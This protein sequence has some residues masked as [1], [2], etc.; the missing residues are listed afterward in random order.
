M[1]KQ[2]DQ[3]T[4][5]QGSLDPYEVAGFLFN[6]GNRLQNIA[7]KSMD[8]SHKGTS[9]YTIFNPRY[10]A[11][12]FSEAL[13][14]IAE[15]PTSFLNAGEKFFRD[16]QRLMMETYKATVSQQPLA[17]V[18]VPEKTDKRFSNDTWEKSL[19]Y[20]YLKQ[21]YLLW[22]RWVSEI[23]NDL[24]GIDPKAAHK[25]QFYTR[26]IVDALSPSN[27][28]LSNPEAARRAVE[29]NGK[30]VFQGI[31]NF[32]R[33]L[34]E[35][36]GTLSIKMVD[37]AAFELGK[38]IATTSG[39]VVYQNDIIQLIQYSPSTEQVF[40]YPIVLIPP[41][42]NR[43]Y[44]F[45]LRSNNSFVK[46][47]VDQGFTVFMVSWVNPDEDLAHKRYEDYVFE[48]VK[49][50]VDVMKEITGTDKV[51][52][53][54]YCIGGNFL[55][56]Y[57]GYAGGDGDQSLNTTSYMAT[58]FDF[59]NSGDLQVFIDEKQLNDIESRTQNKGFLDG[60]TLARTF[61]ILRANDLIWS[62]VINNYLLGEEP[63]AF[64][65]LYWNSHSTNL[66][67]TMYNYYLRNMFHKNLLIKPG[68]LTIGGRPLNLADS[69]TPSF[70]LNTK[71]DHIAPWWCGYAGTKVFSG[72]KKF[73]LGGSGHVAGIFNHPSSGKYGYWTNDDVSKSFNEWFDE[74]TMTPGSW[75]GEWV[76]WLKDYNKKM[77]KARVPGSKM[78]P[79]IEDA[80]GSFVKA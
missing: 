47:L 60:E 6:F 19:Q 80:P 41:C 18:I 7:Q 3:E 1:E 15:N 43:F 56:T 45:D 67:A 25:V 78:H 50:S 38:N 74:A 30:S 79:P 4:K 68:G 29:T 53:L 8:K 55:A 72:P 24:E 52:A 49:A 61:N 46:W 5:Q 54:G 65:L 31:S 63:M 44:I 20:S 58:L 39:K 70:I 11:E 36:S 51:N 33:D 27:Y 75:W 48:G 76:L 17:N 28:I 32:L 69:T 14:K 10:M 21:S 13:V 23:T 2:L 16:Y 22:N 35:G 62:F 37:R 77:V 26:Q 71:D 40:E 42:I 73:V 59:E 12:S 57:S 9:Y 34:D 64:D 66:P